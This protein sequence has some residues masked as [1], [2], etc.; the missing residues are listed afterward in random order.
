[1]DIQRST[2]A[3]SELDFGE[4]ED[5]QIT[6]KIMMLVVGALLILVSVLMLCNLFVARK[7]REI[8]MAQA[9]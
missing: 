8:I 1:M 9:E 7:N 3:I 4:T 2:A 6:F 5:S